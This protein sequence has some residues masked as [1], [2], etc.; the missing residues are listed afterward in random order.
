[1]ARSLLNRNKRKVTPL[2]MYTDMLVRRFQANSNNIDL[3]VTGTAQMKFGYDRIITATSIREYYQLTKIA[4]YMPAQFLEFLRTIEQREDMVGE[5]VGVNLCLKLEPHWIDWNTRQMNLRASVWEQELAESE[6]QMSQQNNKLVTDEQLAATKG[7]DW[8]T[9]SWKYFKEMCS[10]NHSTPVV[11]VYVELCTGVANKQAF[12]N[13]KQASL[14]LQRKAITN[15]FEFKKIKGNLWDFQKLFSPVSAGNPR[16][17]KKAP[18]FPLT[19]EYVAC[20]TDYVPGKLTYD[21]VLM[22]LDMDTGK[23]VYKDF[24]S[25]GGGAEVLLIAAITGGGK[26]YFAKSI[27]F[28]TLLGGYTFVVLDRDGEYIPIAEEIKGTIISMSKGTGR[29]YD[30][31]IIAELTGDEE[32]DSTLLISSQK[33]TTAVFN[34]LADAVEGMTPKELSVFNDA[35]NLLYKQ[36]GISK[37]DRSTWENSRDLS[38]HKLYKAIISMKNDAEYMKRYGEDVLNLIDKLRVFFEPDGIYSYL[39]KEPIKISDVLTKIDGA[40]PMVVLHMD[41]DDDAGR[42]RKDKPTFIKLITTNYLV[43][44]ILTHNRKLNKFTFLNVEEFQRYLYNEFAKGIVVTLVTG[45]RK[46]NANVI[47]ITNNPDELATDMVNDT[48]LQAIRDNI[49]SAMIGKIKSAASIK[50]ICTNLGLVGCDEELYRMA[51][52][53][54]EYKNCF[55]AKF[56]DKEAAMIKAIVPP[57]YRKTALYK[58]RTLKEDLNNG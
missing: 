53:P 48:A 25:S 39:F 43:D 41:L 12:K 17:E 13:L 40:A 54:T 16:M 6:E 33:A 26:S 52:N 21:E 9:E 4:K 32:V 44:T 57:E 24:I 19:D 11:Q 51:T 22:G 23:M 37:D 8:L 10:D 7:N 58:T 55:V 49:T 50:N 3:T 29:Y 14:E 47:V 2:E 1:M 18:R 30:S 20:M 46:K 5:G 45:G 36:Y 15:G 56:D 27:T 31:T 35:Y 42:D 38:F 28:N 34:V